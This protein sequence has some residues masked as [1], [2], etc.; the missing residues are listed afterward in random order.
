MP[1]FNSHAFAP[2]VDDLLRFQPPPPVELGPGIPHGAAR[3]LL[4]RLT[5]ESICE[6]HS[7]RDRS[8]AL[9]CIAGLWLWHNHLDESHS[10]S[11]E[12]GTQE[13][14]FWH[15]IMHRREPDPDNAKY[16]FRRVGEHA[17]YEPLR[18]AAAEALAHAAE[19]HPAASFLSEQ[20]SWDPYRWIDLSESARH[21]NLGRATVELCHRIQIAEWQLLFAH[22]YQRAIE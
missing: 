16:W 20:S 2:L 10:L 19:A 7:P 22:C 6:P 13:G 1:E 17:V 8:M 12:I 11:Q 14:S 4:E 9:A 21:G 3:P 5:V 18:A 15:G